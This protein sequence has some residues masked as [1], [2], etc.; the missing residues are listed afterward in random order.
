MSSSTDV[1][2]VL[3]AV[4][5]VLL[6]CFV[7]GFVLLLVWFGFLML[8]GDWVFAVHGTLFDLTRHELTLIHYCGMALA[9]LCVILF[10]LFPYLAIRLALRNRTGAS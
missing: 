6:W 1:T 10:F 2:E 3:E 8:A 7:L 4:G 9:K 5:K